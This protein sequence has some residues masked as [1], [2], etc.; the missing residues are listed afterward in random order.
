MGDTTHMGKRD[1][2]QEGRLVA[3][4]ANSRGESCD[5]GVCPP[6]QIEH[7]GESCAARCR[8]RAARQVARL[9]GDVPRRRGIFN[10]SKIG[11]L[12]VLRP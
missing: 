6:K 10:L 5:H 1:T 11:R 12:D 8:R 4:A 7:V 9:G 3:T 2:A